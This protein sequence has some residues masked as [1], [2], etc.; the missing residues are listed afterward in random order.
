[1][2]NNE[3]WKHPPSASKISAEKLAE[4]AS[5]PPCAK[6]EKLLDRIAADEGSEVELRGAALQT[7]SGIWPKTALR[8]ARTLTTHPD[9]WLGH[10]AET[11]IQVAGDKAK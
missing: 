3:S 1:M 5:S 9:N 6:L 8:R 4:L 10:T 2:G 7:L 11:V